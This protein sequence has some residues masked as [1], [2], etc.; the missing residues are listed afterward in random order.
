MWEKVYNRI[1][2]LSS[3]F[4]EMWKR[5]S[6]VSLVIPLVQLSRVFSQTHKIG[7]NITNFNIRIN[8]N[9]MLPTMRIEPWTSA[10]QVW[11]SPFWAIQ[12]CFIWRSLTVF[13]SC[14]TWI[15]D[16]DDFVR[17]NRAWV[18]DLKASNLANVNLIQRG[19]HQIWIAEVSGSI[20]TEVTFCC[21]NF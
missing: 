12:A 13:C 3:K 16:S 19:D 10:I 18:Q 17:V 15:L 6:F 20:L 7:G 4:F 11:Y 5:N 2:P 14:T 21:W 9:K 1:T 8:S